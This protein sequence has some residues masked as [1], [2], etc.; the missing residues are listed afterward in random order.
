M[1]KVKKGRKI[2]I[3]IDKIGNGLKKQ[4]EERREGVKMV[5]VC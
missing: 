2:Q 5:S 4:D 1:G 3:G